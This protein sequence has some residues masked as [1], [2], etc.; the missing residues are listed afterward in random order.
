MVNVNL[1]QM[2]ANAFMSM[3]LHV[4]MKKHIRR[5]KSQRCYKA[6]LF[7]TSK[8]KRHSY[9]FGAIA[10]HQAQFTEHGFLVSGQVF[11]RILINS[12]SFRNYDNKNSGEEQ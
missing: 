10:L 1:K 2:K 6:C 3:Y 9:L 5:L 11:P 4:V 8:A 12:T 7:I